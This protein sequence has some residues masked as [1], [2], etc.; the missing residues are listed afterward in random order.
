MDLRNENNIVLE[1]FKVSNNSISHEIDDVV[2]DKSEVLP[3]FCQSLEALL[4]KGIKRGLG[5]TGLVDRD[6]WNVIEGL[7]SSNKVVIKPSL[8]L[9]H[10]ICLVQ[11]CKKTTTTLARGRLFIRI[12]LTKS[13]LHQTFQCLFENQDYVKYW[14]KDESPLVNGKNQK[15]VLELLNM[16]STRLFKLNIKNCSFL[17][18]TWIIPDSQEYEFVPCAFLGITLLSLDGRCIIVQVTPGSVAQEHGIQPGD[19]LDEL[20]SQLIDDKWSQKIGQLKRKNQ[21]K[22]VIATFVKG[23]FSDGHW[24][25]PV[26]QRYKALCNAGK[27]TMILQRDRSNSFSFI[28]P[29]E[30]EPRNKFDVLYIGSYDVGKKGSCK[31]VQ[32]GISKLLENNELAQKKV[33]LELMERDI[34]MNCLE[35]EEII[36]RFSYTETSSCALKENDPTYFGFITGNTTCSFADQ[37]QCHVFKCNTSMMARTIIE[38]I[39]KGFDR[40]IYCV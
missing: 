8:S 26:F 17:N 3:V 25:A 34:V 15:V 22:P 10:T 7:I 29:K 11:Q 5:V 37:F 35:T 33:C 1:Q 40:T 20:F 31:F 19:C 21:G 6:Y 12:A 16:L 30:S 23:Q 39:G 24:F 27:C 36:G 32:N 9:S 28:T 4:Q 14:Y 38:G 18:E 13:L 2:T